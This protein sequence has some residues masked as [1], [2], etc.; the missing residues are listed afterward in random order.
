MRHPL[1]SLLLLPIVGILAFVFWP[2]HGT[3]AS[4]A[5][6]LPGAGPAALYDKTTLFD[7]MD[8]GA[9]D[10]IQNGFISVKVWTGKSGGAEWTEELY[11]F[12][13][14]TQAEKIYQKIKGGAERRFENTVY[15]ADKGSALV[16]SG[17]FLFKVFV[18]PEDAALPERAVHHFIRWIHEQNA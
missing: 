6:D 17:P 11:L 3:G 16:R 12:A 14:D 15:T 7:Y 2:R 1:Y 9:E 13:S 5:S 8:G 10:F 18:Y 4:Y